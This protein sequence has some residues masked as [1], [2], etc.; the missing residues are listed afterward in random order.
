M[1]ESIAM[2]GA[3]TEKIKVFTMFSAL[4][5]FTEKISVL[6][7]DWFSNARDLIHG[8]FVF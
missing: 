4:N 2:F 7:F 8:Y 5:L 6:L 1:S 3:F